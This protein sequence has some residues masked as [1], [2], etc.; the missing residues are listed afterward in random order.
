[1][2]FDLRNLPSAWIVL[3]LGGLAA[4]G[5]C[6]AENPVGSSGVGAGSGDGGSSSSDGGSSSSGDG[7]ESAASLVTA[8]PGAGGGG[9]GELIGDPKTCEQAAEAKTYLGCDFYP[10]VN[11]NAV[12]N[13][14][15]FAVVVANAG[16]EAATVTVDRG[17]ASVASA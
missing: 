9:G 16:D 11:A 2:R 12:W 5:G 6:S 15:D 10:T 13:L 7:G 4:A 1:M 14:F 17:G 3:A 8:G